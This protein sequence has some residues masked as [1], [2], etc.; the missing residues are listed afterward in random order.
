MPTYELI[1]LIKEEKDKNQKE[2]N[3]RKNNINSKYEL[4]KLD[5]IAIRNFSDKDDV[6]RGILEDLESL[7]QRI[8]ERNNGK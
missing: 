7:Q 8:I 4:A 6:L 5:F 1:K 2:L 3:V